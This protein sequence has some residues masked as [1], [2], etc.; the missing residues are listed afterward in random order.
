MSIHGA[1]E[2]ERLALNAIVSAEQEN[3]PA[4][5]NAKMVAAQTYATL[6]VGARIEETKK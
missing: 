4:W 3:D 1:T 5:A 6:S 2:Y